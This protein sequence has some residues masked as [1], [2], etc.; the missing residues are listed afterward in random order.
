MKIRT[1]GFSLLELMI[2]VAII[3]VLSTVAIPQYQNYVTRAKWTVN[4]TQL[5]ALKLSVAECLINHGNLPAQ[6]ISLPDL[7][8]QEWP[9]AQYSDTPASVSSKGNEVVIDIVGNAAAGNCRV[10]LAAQAKDQQLSWTR[11]NVGNGSTTACT[12]QKTG[13]QP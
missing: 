8:L 6:C 9:V 10:R 3:A 4:L 1:A 13:I 2:V 7:G 12:R 11:S 5:E